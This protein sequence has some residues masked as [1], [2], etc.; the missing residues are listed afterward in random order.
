MPGENMSFRLKT[1]LG[2]ALI[3]GVLLVLMVLSAQKFLRESN[4]EQFVQRANSTVSLFSDATKN[5]VIATDLALLDSFVE[6]IST[7]AEVVYVRVIGQDDLVLSQAGVEEALA[8][9]FTP[10]TDMASLDDAV[11]DIS[12]PINESG[13][14]YGR[15][16]IGFSNDK[17]A[18]LLESSQ[19]TLTGIAV[20]EILLVALFSYLLGTY[21]T[22]QLWYLKKGAEKL[23]GGKLGYQL[24]VKGSDELAQT[25]V[26]FNRM[27]RK[28]KE[29]EMRKDAYMHSALHGII[30]L[31]DAGVITEL[32]GA[33]EVLFVNS[34]DDM[35]GQHLSEVM[36]LEQ[37]DHAAYVTALGQ[38]DNGIEIFS[39]VH[40]SSM[41][42]GVGA[43]VHLQWVISEVRLDDEK[44]FVV[45]AEN[46]NER[47][48]AELSLIASTLAAQEANDAKSE[49]LANMT[50]E[51]RTPLQGII[52]FSSLGVKR[53]EK[54]SP[55]KVKK[56]FTTI[57]DS[58]NTLLSLVN[59]LLDLTKLQSGKMNYQFYNGDLNQSIGSVVSELRGQCK[60]RGLT[61]KH[62]DSDTPLTTV[63][64]ASKIDQVMRNL[65]SNAIKF[66]PEN[67]EITVTTEDT[68][69][70][71]KVCVA[72]NGPGIPSGELEIVFDKFSQ[73]SVTKD[74]SGGTGLGLPICREII[75]AHGGEISA[76]SLEGKGAV[77]TFTLPH[78][79]AE[80]ERDEQLLSSSASARK[81]A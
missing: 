76:D 17:I 43:I 18:Q 80:V 41:R 28:L 30:T 1:I 24:P 50:H 6:E 38:P 70:A 69:N 36:S 5:A 32:N 29:S 34:R 64:D 27:S 65:L 78:G 2:I 35:I 8:R 79:I 53:S 11:F 14:T 20:V 56:Y 57:Q 10:D 54:A 73:S 7:N 66:S 46:I 42:N 33:A 47:K 81:A 72:D 75:S 12:S 4:Q 52:G 48:E 26:S 39:K 61:I 9:Q 22:H 55:E 37:S 62:E 58:A 21:L 60:E 77:F 3:E 45:F 40:E 15:V 19:R 16:E 25:V 67:S 44:I 63:Y 71:I 31:N 68:G 74:G 49:F 59:N 13:Y 23:A 51:L